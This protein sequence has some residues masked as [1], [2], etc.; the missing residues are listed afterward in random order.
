MRNSLSTALLLVSLAACVPR[1]A[2]LEGSGG[3]GGLDTIRA[4]ILLAIAARDYEHARD[5]LELAEG[6]SQTE[7]DRLGWMIEAA[8]RRL[9]PFL[10]QALPHIFKPDPGHFA[11][12]TAEARELIQTTVTDAYFVGK[13]EVGNLVY[14][15]LLETGKQ[16]WV[17]VRNGTIRDAGCNDMPW[18]VQD[19]LQ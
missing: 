13:S 17:F 3:P 12:D 7:R 2:P 5:L 11:E 14:A 1:Y 9:V 10:E 19:L 18:P 8:E 16:I 15:R 6:F 4:K